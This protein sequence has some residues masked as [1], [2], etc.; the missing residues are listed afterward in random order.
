MSSDEVR[1]VYL[2]VV[3]MSAVLLSV[4]GLDAGYGDFQALFGVDARGRGR[5]RRSR[6]SV[7]TAPARRTLLR[8]IAGQVTVP[9][10]RRSA[11]AVTTSLGVARSRARRPRASRWCPR[12]GGC[13]RSLTVEENLE[14]GAYAGPARRLDRRAGGRHCSR[15]SNDCSSAGRRAVRWRAAGGG[16]RPCADG[17][18][19]DCS[20]S[21][22]SRSVSLRSWCSSSTT[23]SPQSARPARP[24]SSSSRTSRQ[25]LAV[26]D[27][28]DCMLEGRVSL[29]GPRPAMLDHDARSRLRTSGSS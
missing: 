21:T 17:A 2:G 27:Q 15:C 13:S 25:A 26:A 16:D 19:R 24:A 12:A 8:A 18:T 20:C 22:R 29:I 9:M 7:P 6:S 23:R 11:S 28:V 4:E 3:G 5:A 1:E 10:R 14:I